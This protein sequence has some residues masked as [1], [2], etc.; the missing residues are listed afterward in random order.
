MSI[1]AIEGWTQLLGTVYAKETSN[2]EETDYEYV[3]IHFQSK[4][5][6]QGVLQW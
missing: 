6:Q 3:G 1:V 2:K 5:G 4:S